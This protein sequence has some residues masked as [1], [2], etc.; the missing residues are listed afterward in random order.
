MLHR[1][2]A[3]TADRV[4]LKGDNY[5]QPDHLFDRATLIAI[6][7]MVLVNGE[8]IPMR[9]RP[10]PGAVMRLR[11]LRQRLRVAV[12]GWLRGWFG[13]RRS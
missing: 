7:D 10:H 4:E 9:A 8:A 5:F 6:A 2:R 13:T 11:Q 12:S 1:V 3:V